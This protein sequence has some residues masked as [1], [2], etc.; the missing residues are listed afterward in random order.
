MRDKFIRF[1]QGRYRVDELGRFMTGLS[2]VV[3][4][5]D[6]FTRSK[7]MNILFWVIIELLAMIVVYGVLLIEMIF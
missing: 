1:M 3:I 2:L 5:L 4:V 7:I 6:M